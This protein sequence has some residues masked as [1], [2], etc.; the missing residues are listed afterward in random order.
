MTASEDNKSPVGAHRLAATLAWVSGV[1]LMLTAPAI[2]ASGPGGD[3]AARSAPASAT[4]CAMDPYQASSTQRAAC[5]LKAFP[6]QD[7]STIRGG[8]A[9]GATAY[10]YNVNGVLTKYLV[11]PSSFDP[12]TA[13]PDQLRAYAIPT[14]P[15]TSDPDGRARW[16][17]MAHN[18]HF[19]PAPPALMNSTVRATQTTFPSQNW[20]GA[21]A[22]GGPGAITQSDA[23][24]G[25]PNVY[26]ASGCPT[27]TQSAAFWT[28]IGGLNT[29]ALAQNGTITTV[30]GMQHQAWFELRPDEP[31]LIPIPM[32]ATVGGGFLVNTYYAGN[33]TFGFGFYNYANGQF[34]SFVQTGVQNDYD[35]STGENIAERP[36]FSGRYLAALPDFGFVGFYQTDLNGQRANDD[37]YYPID[38]VNPNPLGFDDHLAYPYNFTSGASYFGVRWTECL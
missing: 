37:N 22:I 8:R 18:M 32:Y 9:D 35:G 19:A 30:G 5:G 12:A 11:P 38:M 23:I 24:Y 6:R 16:L 14:E 34:M 20:S 4:S 2:A 7:V 15:A 33:N 27:S 26:F 10:T 36:T 28:G 29:V 31:S 21:I 17:T 1:M 13:T 25:E 3:A